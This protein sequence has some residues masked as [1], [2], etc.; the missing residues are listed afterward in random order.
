VTT[1]DN[2]HKN[3]NP[4]N[5]FKI[6]ENTDQESSSTVAGMNKEGSAVNVLP[7]GPSL[8]V[9]HINNLQSTNILTTQGITS[10]SANE[11]KIGPAVDETDSS[12]VKQNTLRSSGKNGSDYD[13]M[14]TNGKGLA[15]SG[16]IL[17]SNGK[18]EISVVQAFTK[19]NYI[20]KS[21]ISV[22]DESNK[23]PSY[24]LNDMQ[25]F[26]PVKMS[27]SRTGKSSTDQVT[28]ET[29]SIMPN[30]AKSSFSTFQASVKV[31][32]TVPASLHNEK[33][34]PV[35]MLTEKISHKKDHIAK[36]RNPSTTTKS[37]HGIKGITD[38][39]GFKN[40][41]FSLANQ[42]ES[43]T[44]SYFFTNSVVTNNFPVTTISKEETFNFSTFAFNND[45]FDS[46]LMIRMQS[47]PKSW[48]TDSYDSEKNKR[49]DNTTKLGLRKD[50]FLPIKT[51]KVEKNKPYSEPKLNDSGSTKLNVSTGNA[52]N[53]FLVNK[54]IRNDVEK[55]KISTHFPDTNNGSNINGFSIENQSQ[56]VNSNAKITD[57]IKTSQDESLGEDLIHSKT[58]I[59]GKNRMINP[60]KNAHIVFENQEISI[61]EN[62]RK[63]VQQHEVSNTFRNNSNLPI[64]G[65]KNLNNN[66]IKSKNE[67]FPNKKGQSIDNKK[68]SLT[69]EK[70][71]GSKNKS[72]NDLFSNKTVSP[73]SNL[74]DSSMDYLKQPKYIKNGN[75]SKELLQK[76][77]GS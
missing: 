74:P 17:P 36:T 10:V 28:S 23:V 15:I 12:D 70:L 42:V 9:A 18:K 52:T 67:I 50:P 72:S 20:E 13:V 8:N 16:S 3:F 22:F 75:T 24:N 51:L 45:T 34:I 71:I 55:E 68:N 30:Q 73:D 26:Y 39:V 37:V 57:P 27:H 31:K 40:L 47:E 44:T 14:T 64:N 4:A 49:P 65:G 7:T 53:P 43:F 6:L 63:S 19:P 29:K 48:S 11:K 41:S 77:Q 56:G 38:D 5:V 32:S 59:S 2:H 60:D 69:P 25:I 35:E 61:D 54:S 66:S 1:F 76:F 46:P 62:F 21:T 33:F 58:N